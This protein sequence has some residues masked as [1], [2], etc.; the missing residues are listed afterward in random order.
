MS[1][2][3]VTLSHRLLALREN[4]RRRAEL[5]KA[6]AKE[7][8]ERNLR[9][10][11]AP[12]LEA[13]RRAIDPDLLPLA[14]LQVGAWR[15]LGDS[16]A[17]TAFVEIPDCDTPIG[18]RFTKQPNGQWAWCPHE[19][20]G[21]SGLYAV[22]SHLTDDLGEALY[23]ASEASRYMTGAALVIDGGYTLW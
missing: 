14:P 4:Y 22:G 13:M 1:T 19:V 10:T 21:R 11:V 15:D 16:T 20:S 9:E 3:P 5:E 17:V 18:Y 7:E 2:A 23:L 8:A 12:L 6:R